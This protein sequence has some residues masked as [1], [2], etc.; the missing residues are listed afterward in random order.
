MKQLLIPFLFLTFIFMSCDENRVFDDYKSMED[1]KWNINAPVRFEV[2]V[3][4]S[5]EYCNIF[6]KVRNN[7]DYENK[8]LWMFVKLI[9]PNGEIEIDSKLDCTLADDEGRWLGKGLGDIYDSSHKL[10][11]NFRFKHSGI[12][13]FE[14]IHGMR[15][16]ILSGV[17]DIGLRV[18]KR[19]LK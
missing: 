5:S 12:Y 9:S 11:E 8:N 10:K 14:I 15:K 16:S 6:L 13:T 1:Y 2:N 4:D 7:Q 19:K 17:R 3:Q 18:E